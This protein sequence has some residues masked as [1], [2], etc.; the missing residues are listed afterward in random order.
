MGQRHEA[1][2]CNW[3]EA[4]RFGLPFA[5]HYERFEEPEAFGVFARCPCC[6]GNDFLAAA[7][8]TL[9]A[10]DALVLGEIV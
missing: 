3:A 4:D 5:R 6:P 10:L 1:H 7:A 9:D 2:G 8:R